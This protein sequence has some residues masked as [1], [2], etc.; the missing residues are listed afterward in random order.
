M[1][2]KLVLEILVIGTIILLFAPIIGSA[3][4]VKS[5]SNNQIDYTINIKNY[6]RI[7]PG[8]YTNLTI[9]EVWE[10]ISDS[11]NGI[12]ILIDVRTP[13]EYINERIYTPSFLEKPR[14]FPLQMMQRNEIFLRI[15]MMFYKDREVILYCRS[16]NRSFIATQ[17]LIDHGFSGE[18]YNMIG[19]IT[20]WNAADLPTAK[21][22][23]PINFGVK[24]QLKN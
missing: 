18:I 1:K 12:Q 3:I 11:S 9:E 10:L 16:A 13:G 5:I 15:F 17:L 23:F 8:G 22:L 14:L 21:G 4:T 24:K 7:D 20:E 2:N 6:D 19:G